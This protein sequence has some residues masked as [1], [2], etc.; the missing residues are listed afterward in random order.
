MDLYSVFTMRNHKFQHL[1]PSVDM[2]LG[3]KQTAF[4]TAYFCDS[5]VFYV[6]VISFS[7]ML[8]Q[9]EKLII[10]CSF[11]YWRYLE[12]LT[13][14]YPV[15]SAISRLDGDTP[16]SFWYSSMNCKMCCI[17]SGLFLDLIS[18]SFP[19]NGSFV[20]FLVCIIAE[21]MWNVNSSTFSTVMVLWQQAPI[22]KTLYGC[23][24]SNRCFCVLDNENGRFYIVLNRFK[25]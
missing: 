7:V 17:R 12:T 9:P 19:Q 4:P 14:G 21:L 1:F 10:F 24:K 6:V 13:G 20:P 11:M 16:F 3:H 22:L 18:T 15:P 23:T 25:N 5:A 8:R 2:C